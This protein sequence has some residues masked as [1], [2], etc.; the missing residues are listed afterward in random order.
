VKWRLTVLLERI[1]FEVS[2]IPH[3]HSESF[4]DFEM[5]VKRYYFWI[6]QYL[7]LTYLFLSPG[8]V[9]LGLKKRLNRFYEL[10]KFVTKMTKNENFFG[11]L[12]T[13]L[14]GLRAKSQI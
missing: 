4:R 2:S 7:S 14:L 5:A 13:R 8:F 11:I 3:F 1:G 12:D 9:L 6:E 10:T